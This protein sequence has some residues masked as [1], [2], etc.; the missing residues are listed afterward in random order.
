MTI[1]VSS[2][3]ARNS[4][5]RLLRLA[6]EENEEVVIRVRGEPTA[7]LVSYAAYEQLTQLKRI[8]KA[9]EALAKIQAA[10]DRVQAKVQDLP[11]EEAYRQAGF[12]EQ[13]IQE[14]LAHEQQAVEPG[15]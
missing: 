14:L 13:A 7:V 10:R 11:P 9:Q 1:N 3:E 5:G 12:G 4:L 6:S 2:N 8:Q 15:A